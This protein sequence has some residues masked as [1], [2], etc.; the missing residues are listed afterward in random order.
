MK[1]KR[2]EFF[3]ERILIHKN[4]KGVIIKKEIMKEII[5]KF[6]DNKFS[7]LYPILL[8]NKV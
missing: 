5:M 2:I 3:L 7:E 6:K 1:I 4:I 8:M